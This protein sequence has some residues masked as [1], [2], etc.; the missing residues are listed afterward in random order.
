MAKLRSMICGSFAY[1]F[2]YSGFVGSPPVFRGEATGLTEEALVVASS[3]G[4]YF[5]AL[6]YP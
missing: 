6:T 1:R 5:D 2:G 4:L 3:E